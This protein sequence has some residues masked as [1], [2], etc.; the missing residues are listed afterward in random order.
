MAD[1]ATTA[2]A[3]AVAPDAP[4]APQL[5]LALPSGG[6]RAAS[7]HIGLLAR[8]AEGDL[9]RHADAIST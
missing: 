4:A 9:L 1:P 8:L 2:Q 5:G 3:P 6:F 7:F